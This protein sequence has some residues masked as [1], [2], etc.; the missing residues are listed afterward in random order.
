MRQLFLRELTRVTE[1]SQV[2]GEHLSNRHAR[3]G[4]ALS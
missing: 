1:S 3:E 4:I 2:A